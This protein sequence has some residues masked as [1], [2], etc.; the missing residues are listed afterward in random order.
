MEDIA[1]GNDPNDYAIGPKLPTDAGLLQF[2]DDFAFGV[3]VVDAIAY[4]GTRLLQ[5]YAVH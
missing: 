1:R 4:H 5:R 2:Y 3:R